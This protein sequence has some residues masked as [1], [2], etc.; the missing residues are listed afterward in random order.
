MIAEAA[1][2]KVLGTAGITHRVVTNDVIE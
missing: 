1:T 2:I